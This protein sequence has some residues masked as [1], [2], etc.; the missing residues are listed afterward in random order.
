MNRA[1]Y[2]YSSLHTVTLCDVGTV[3][4]YSSYMKCRS[5]CPHGLRCG[6]AAARFLGLQ[7]QIPS[8]TWMYVVLFFMGRILCV[9]LTTRPEE[10]YQLWCA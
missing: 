3:G 5:G 1:C 10:S 7:V 4:V 9:G 8:G 6:S 2:I